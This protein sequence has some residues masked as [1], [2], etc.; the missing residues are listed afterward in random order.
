MS[1]TCRCGTGASSV[2][3]NHC[4]QSARRLAWQLGQKYRHLHENASRYSCAQSSQRKRANPWSEDAAGE[5]LVG[6][7]RDHEAS[8]AV[9]T[10]ETGIVDRVQAM[11]VV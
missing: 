9:L 8:R 2:R 3:S 4:V 6:H 10:R 7:L 11:Q 5:E 1:T